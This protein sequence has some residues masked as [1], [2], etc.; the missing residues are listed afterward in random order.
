MDELVKRLRA[1][2]CVFAEDEASILH[3]AAGTAA[4]LEAMV[5]RR[6]DGEPLEYVVGWAEFG[7]RKIAVAPGVFVPRKRTELLLEQALARTEPGATV[8]ELCAGAAAVSAAL[9]ARVTVG[10]LHAVD[11]D[12]DAVACATRNVAGTVYQGDLFQPLPERLRGNV[13][14]LIANAPYVP[15]AGIAYMPA[16]AR[17]H[18]HRVALDGGADG[19]DVLRRIIDQAA[20]WLKRGGSLIVESGREQARQVADAMTTNGLTARITTRHE[21]TAVIGTKPRRGASK[22]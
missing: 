1:A 12:P 13:D 14:I 18:E 3:E 20:A 4:E 15:T 16:E 21:A 17:E 8:V 19:L 9:A 22:S 2:G 6:V 10:E 5:A 7:G 11:I